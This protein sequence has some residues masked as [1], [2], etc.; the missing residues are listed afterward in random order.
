MK[1]VR[2]L[3]IMALMAYFFN[4]YANDYLKLLEQVSEEVWAWNIP[5]FSDYTVPEEYSEESAVVLVQHRQIDA[6]ANKSTFGKQFFMGINTGKFFY[7]DI[8]RTLVKLNDQAA[9]NNF[10]EFKFK[11][12]DKYGFQLGYMNNMKTVIGVRIVKSDGTIETVNILKNTVSITEGK[13]DQKKV[14]KKLAVPGLQKGDIIDFFICEIYEFETFVLQPQALPFYTIDYPALHYSYRLA[15][16]KNLTIEYRSINGAPEFTETKNEDGN[17]VLEAERKNNIFR[18]NDGENVKWAS[19]F[20]DLPMI[21]FVI[22]QNASKAIYKPISARSIGVHKNVP[23]EEILEDKKGFYARY[24]SYAN[25]IKLSK[26]AELAILD[27]K[28]INSQASKEELADFIYTVLNFEWTGRTLYHN[29]ESFMWKLNEAF[30]ENNIESRI[31]F[32]TNKYDAHKDEIISEEDLYYVTIANEGKQFFAPPYKYR[33]AGEIPSSYQGEIASTFRVDKV[34]SKVFETNSAWTLEGTPKEPIMIP[35]T[36]SGQNSQSAIIEIAFNADDMQKLDIKRK[37]IKTG[38]P[39]FEFQY[40]MI[41]HEDWD[42]TMRNYFGAD[43]KSLL[44]ELEKNKKNKKVKKNI[45]TI[46]GNFEKAREEHI[47]KMKQEI[48]MYHGT[49]PEKINEYEFLSL[50][51]TPDQPQ[52]EYKIDYVM[53]GLVRI[54]GDN[55][56]LDAGKLMGTQWNPTDNDRVRVVDAYLP[57][58]NINEREIRIKV[59]DGYDANDIS[60]L[61]VSYSNNYALFESNATTEND[62]IVL[63]IKKTYLKSFVPKEDWAEII[64]IADR[65]NEFYSR[66]LIFKKK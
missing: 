29:T 2:Y 12:Q 62:T 30:K 25:M 34:N 56:I 50:G 9:I 39:K 10:S 26:K 63:K 14:H 23:Y 33:V 47:E 48:N 6:T 55:L 66:S 54:A 22:L 24:K 17:I 65:T 19:S 43:D 44:E 42:K 15:F 7:T 27:Y 16:G 31:A 46:S 38:N 51:I 61:N 1:K 11:D 57:T 37:E 40:W 60:D 18:I 53:D 4:T 21:R 64:Y 49:D 41:L 5:A 35:E 52:F 28:V 58:A 59:P 13:G 36:T 45:E 8:T 20:R 32:V 3:M